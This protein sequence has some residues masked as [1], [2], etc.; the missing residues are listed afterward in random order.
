MMNDTDKI[1][2][3]EQK[4]LVLRSTLMHISALL[5]SLEQNEVTDEIRRC[6]STASLVIEYN[7]DELF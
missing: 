7:E 1:K 5:E 2:D 6:I 3:L 4:N